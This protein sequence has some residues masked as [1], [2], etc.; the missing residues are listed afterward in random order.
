M[1][2][3]AVVVKS[4]KEDLIA[5]ILYHESKR[6]NY[7]IYSVVAIP[8][9]KG[10]IFVEAKNSLEVQRAVLGIASVK[11]V[12]PEEVDIKEIE[13]YFEEEVKVEDIKQGYIVE[14]LMG[15]LK[16]ARGRVVKIDEKKKELTV[17]LID[18]PVPVNITLPINGV[19]V[20]EKK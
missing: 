6:R 7:E 18:V 12:L 20:I 14:I 2:F 17:E 13:K 5:E 16:G 8:G 1:P 11:K 9:L 10:F 4:G 19:K 3:Y 15:A